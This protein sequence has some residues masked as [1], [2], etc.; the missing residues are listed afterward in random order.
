MVEIVKDG[1]LQVGD[2]GSLLLS[3]AMP[4]LVSG[5]GASGDH[6]MSLYQP[7]H[8]PLPPLPADVDTVDFTWVATNTVSVDIL[9]QCLM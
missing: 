9:V 2:D 8:E 3:P 1:E 5:S 4:S 6:E 7:S